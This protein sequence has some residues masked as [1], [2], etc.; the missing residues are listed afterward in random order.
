MDVRGKKKHKGCSNKITKLISGS[1]AYNFME[2]GLW[3]KKEWPGKKN[4]QLG[5]IF[6]RTVFLSMSYYLCSVSPTSYTVQRRED[7]REEVKI[8]KNL[9]FSNHEKG[10]VEFGSQDNVHHML[11]S[12]NLG[13]PGFYVH[14]FRLQKRHPD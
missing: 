12:A 2:A 3:L 1:S 7:E 13:I 5:W 10:S 8:F 6:S 14:I 11:P 4:L 9:L